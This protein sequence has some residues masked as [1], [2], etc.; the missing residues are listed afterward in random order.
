MKNNTTSW[1]KVSE[2]YNDHLS[3]GDSYHTK[4]ILPNILRL[5]DIKKEDAVLDLACGTG[6]FTKHFSAV[7]EN[8]LGVDISK[9]LIEYAKKNAPNAKF[10]VTD[11]ADL[12]KVGSESFGKISCI[13]ALQNIENIKKTF[14]ECFRVL[15]DSGSFF[16][17][18]NHPAFRI[19]KAS[20]WEYD[21]KTDVQYRRVESYLSQSKE[22]IVMHPGDKN[23]PKT[24]SFH[25]SLQDYFKAATAAGFVV[26]RLEEWISHK[27]SE[28]GPKQKAEDKA[29]KEIP[30]FLMIEFKK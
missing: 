2:W 15:V 14:S 1:G 17:V 30:L 18:I 23:S 3:S 16:V 5:V 27:K 12:S 6:F 25:R 8:V 7:S 19:P 10:L 24:V 22:E 13:L 9:E 29:R 21:Q 4:V 11:A 20:A 26:T 28:F